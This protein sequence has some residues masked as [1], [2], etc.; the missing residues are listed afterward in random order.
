MLNPLKIIYR[1][2]KYHKLRHQIRLLDD[3][4]YERRRADRLEDILKREFSHEELK[5]AEHFRGIENKNKRLREEVR[6]MQLKAEEFNRLLYATGLIVHCTGCIAGAP[7]HYKD[8]TEEKVQQVE[9]IARRL[10]LWWNCN[11]HRIN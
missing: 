4:Y 5:R 7:D 11:K 3:W 8:L 2:F 10:R 1:Y 6:S 9:Q